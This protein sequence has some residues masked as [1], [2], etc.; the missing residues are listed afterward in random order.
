VTWPELRPGKFAYAFTRHGVLPLS[1]GDLCRGFPD[2]WPSEN[3]AKS[4]LSRGSLIGCNP[5]IVYLFGVCTQL[6]QPPLQATYRRKAQKGKPARALVCADLPDPRAI[7]ESLVGELTEFHV[8]HPPESSAK[9]R[10]PERERLPQRPLPPL[11]AALSAEGHL[12]ATL[13]PD[14]RPPDMLG[15]AGVMKLMTLATELAGAERAAVA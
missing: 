10:E 7:L 1:A 14:G 12:L 13:P 11:A 15:M 8:E 2:L 6:D 3:T 4:D 5:Q 9:P